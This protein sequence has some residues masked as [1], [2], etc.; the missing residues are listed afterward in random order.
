MRS[1]ISQLP[2]GMI[3]KPISETVAQ[4]C[5]FVVMG[6]EL[7]HQPPLLHKAESDRFAIPFSEEDIL[8]Q[9]LFQLLSSMHI[10]FY[11]AKRTWRFFVVQPLCAC[12]GICICSD[13]IAAVAFCTCGD[14]K[15]SHLKHN[16]IFTCATAA[17][18]G[19]EFNI[20]L[21]DHS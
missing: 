19:V 4:A 17:M 1:L 7:L 6:H 11:S 13:Q 21:K 16:G 5:L 8:P 9:R 2:L 14:A 12:E 3:R 18:H 20:F 15:K 10:S